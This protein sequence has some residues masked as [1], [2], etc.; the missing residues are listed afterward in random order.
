MTTATKPIVEPSARVHAL[1]H[2]H[3]ETRPVFERFGIHTCCGGDVPLA[4]AA[5]RDGADLDALLAALREALAADGT[6]TA[7]GAGAVPAA[8]AARAREAAP[9]PTVRLLD[10]TPVEPKDR[11]ETILRA[12]DGL[13]PGETLE[14][15][16]DHDPMCVYYTLRAEREPGVGIEYLEPGPERWRVRVTRPPQ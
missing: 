6:G 8:E 10:V 13:A 7:A 15:V 14:L 4:A 3:P 5:E 2:A 16:V 1:L 12:Y 11:L 9:P